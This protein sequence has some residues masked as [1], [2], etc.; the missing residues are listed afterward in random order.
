[1]YL[2]QVK[3]S[4]PL[5]GGKLEGFALDNLKKELTRTGEFTVAQLAS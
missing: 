5:V 3:S 2:G 1:V 4:V